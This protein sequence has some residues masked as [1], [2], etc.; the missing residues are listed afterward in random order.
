MTGFIR[1]LLLV[2]S[3]LAVGGCSGPGVYRVEP[4]AAHVL[5]DANSES[6]RC[7]QLF[8]SLDSAVDVTG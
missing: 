4:A 2:L 6:G 1:G 8:A 7:I 5:L 3:V